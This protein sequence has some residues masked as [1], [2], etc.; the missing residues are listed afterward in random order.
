MEPSGQMTGRQRRNVSPPISYRKDDQS[1]HHPR[2]L[3]LINH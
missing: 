1:S 3:I 2:Q